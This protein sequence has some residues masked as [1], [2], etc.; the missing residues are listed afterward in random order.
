MFPEWDV[1]SRTGSFRMMV[2][3]DR[4]SGRPKTFRSNPTGQHCQITTSHVTRRVHVGKKNDA[5]RDC[6][7][8]VAKTNTHHST[9][10]VMLMTI[11]S[12]RSTVCSSRMTSRQADTEASTI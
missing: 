4:S 7:F 6:F 9:Q 8:W 12:C 5:Y 2:T 1:A 10:L 3:M 11:A